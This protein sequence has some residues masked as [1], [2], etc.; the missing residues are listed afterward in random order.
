MI[1]VRVYARHSSD[2]PKVNDRNWK[3]CRCPKWFAISGAHG[4]PRRQSAGTRSWERAEGK[5]RLIERSEDLPS[6]SLTVVGAVERFLTD[7]HNQGLAAGSR[8]NY[9]LLLQKRLLPWL[10][11]RGID[12]LNQIELAHLEDFRASLDVQAS[13]K[14]VKQKYL[15]AFFAY[16]HKHG[17]LGSNLADGL[18]QVKVRQ[19]QT[20]YFRPEEFAAIRKAAEGIDQQ[21]ATFVD[22]LR[23]AG[24]RIGDA[25]QLERSRL[26]E[27]GRL[28]LYAMKTGDV[29][30]VPIRPEVAEAMRAI[31]SSRYFFWNGVSY[32]RAVNQWQ[33]KLHQ[34]FDIAAIGKRC[35]A[36][37]FRDTFAV[38]L[39]LA[40]LPIDHVSRMLGHKS[41]KT[42][43]QFYSP[44]VR[45]RQDQLEAAVVASWK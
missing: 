42:T 41:V 11:E 27:H 8:Y 43:E 9:E 22:C 36:H 18:S 38:E 13:S 24:L 17:W 5:A 39:L 21:L 28:R 16:C 19:R 40:G 29:V 26:D 4:F 7:K 1:T 3:R 25:I 10:E 6:N 37:M 2:C 31:P 34:A 15:K 12:D 45:A 20:D 30:V 14:A 32:R 44:W 33:Y 35:H 23:W